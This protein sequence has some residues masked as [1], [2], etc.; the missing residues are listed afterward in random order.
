MC[1][2]LPRHEDAGSRSTLGASGSVP[3]CRRTVHV[4]DADAHGGTEGR[5]G[6][7]AGRRVTVRTGLHGASCGLGFEE[8]MT[9]LVFAR[10]DGDTLAAGLC[11]RT[12]RIQRAAQDVRELNRIADEER[13]ERE[14]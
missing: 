2:G 6:A 7:E 4:C 8:G 10:A 3:G 5:A 1:R 12:A 11:S 9:Y 13:S 14:R